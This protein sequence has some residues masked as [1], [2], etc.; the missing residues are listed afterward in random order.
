M[1]AK[2]YHSDGY[3]LKNCLN[4]DFEIQQTP[5]LSLQQYARSIAPIPGADPWVYTY[6]RKYSIPTYSLKPYKDMKSKPHESIWHP[7]SPYREKP[8]T[9]LSPEKRWQR[10]VREPIWQPSSTIQYKSVPYFD[11]P[12]LRWSFEQILKSLPNLQ[13]DTFDPSKTILISKKRNI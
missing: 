13:A 10:S 3:S 9:S 1:K 4:Y 5:P 7:V 8:P 11:P 6:K 2:L 12:A